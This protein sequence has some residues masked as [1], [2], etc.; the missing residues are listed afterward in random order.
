MVRVRVKVRLRVYSRV[1][2]RI[3][4]STKLSVRAVRLQRSSVYWY[5]VE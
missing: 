1:I 2:T 4:D 3:P 5:R